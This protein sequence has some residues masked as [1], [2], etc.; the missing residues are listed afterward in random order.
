MNF[1]LVF[2]YHTSQSSD[3]HDTHNPLHDPQPEN[4]AGETIEPA[5]KA[6]L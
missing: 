4:D 6:K 5:E 1:G 3:R 2:L